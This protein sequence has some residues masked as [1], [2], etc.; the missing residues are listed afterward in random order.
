MPPEPGKDRTESSEIRETHGEVRIVAD[1]E[2]ANLD[3]HVVSRDFK[4]PG[5]QRR[6]GVKIHHWRRIIQLM[7]RNTSSVALGDVAHRGRRAKDEITQVDY[8][9]KP[10]AIPRQSA[11]KR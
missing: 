2:P 5:D 6:E 9:R 1:P 11:V 10:V 4:L 7:D 3:A 8:L